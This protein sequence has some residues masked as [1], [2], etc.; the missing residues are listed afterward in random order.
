MID[1]HVHLE[2]GDY[3]VERIEQFIEYAVKRNY[4]AYPKSILDIF[5]YSLHKRFVQMICILKRAVG[6]RLNM[7]ISS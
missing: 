6:W 3:S 7:A 1:A 4:G 5:I 2:K